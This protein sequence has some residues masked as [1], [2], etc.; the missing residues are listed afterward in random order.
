MD[1]GT[2]GG[3]TSPGL[4]QDFE[5]PNPKL[6]VG[7][8]GYH[9]EEVRRPLSHHSLWTHMGND[10]PTCMPNLKENKTKPLNTHG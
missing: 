2:H 4:L 3:A 1:V 10:D 7:G 5:Y 8:R 9:D 6:L